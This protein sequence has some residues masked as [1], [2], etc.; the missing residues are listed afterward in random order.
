MVKLLDEPTFDDLNV[1]LEGLEV[2]CATI[3][4]ASITYRDPSFLIFSRL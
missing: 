4:T 2:S 3:N 1:M